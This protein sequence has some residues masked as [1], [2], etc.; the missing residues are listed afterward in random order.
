MQSNKKDHSEATTKK[1]QSIISKYIT[2]PFDIPN[3]F[4]ENKIPILLS[5]Y[6]APSITFIIFAL[7]Y[8]FK[9][10]TVLNF[11]SSILVTLTLGMTL[12]INVNLFY[13]QS[14]KNFTKKIITF[15]FRFL[16]AIS[17]DMFC[18]YI[19]NQRTEIINNLNHTKNF[20]S[21]I[22]TLFIFSAITL[23]YLFKIVREGYKSVLNKINLI[24][25][26]DGKSAAKMTLFGI[27]ATIIVGILSFFGAI[28]A[29]IIANK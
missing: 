10:F 25:T 4:I 6:L 7:I 3:W 13:L 2:N 14:S 29:A 21:F 22:S 16:F 8:G 5:S 24:N 26:E 15:A 28:I 9:N 1:I 18:F 27:F 12:G 20:N 19:I 23:F 17:L 11:T